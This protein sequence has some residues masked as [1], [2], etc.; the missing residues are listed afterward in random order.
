MMEGLDRPL[1]HSGPGGSKNLP[2]LS[3]LRS[4]GLRVSAAQK[5]SRCLHIVP[6]EQTQSQGFSWRESVCTSWISI[7]QSWPPLQLEF[8]S[9]CEF[10]TTFVNL[11]W[12]HS[13]SSFSLHRF[14]RKLC[15]LITI[16]INAS[17]GVLMAISPNYT[18]MLIFRLIQGLVSKAGWLIGYILS[19]N[20]CDFSC[21]NKGWLAK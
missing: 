4:V 10:S 2:S 8:H 12:C 11:I 21:G 16:L 6:T 18:W 19:K 3:T 13:L 9:L 1:G 5:G 14:G 7:L 15:L 17:S 20:T